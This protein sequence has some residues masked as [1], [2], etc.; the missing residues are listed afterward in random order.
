MAM[1]VRSASGVV[2]CAINELIVDKIGD[3]DSPRNNY[4]RNVGKKL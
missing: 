3:L 2:R 4:L 1:F